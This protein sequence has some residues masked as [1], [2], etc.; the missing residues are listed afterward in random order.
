MPIGTA[1]GHP[2][3]RGCCRTCAG[4]A[5]QFLTRRQTSSRQ[6]GGQGGFPGRCFSLLAPV[7]WHDQKVAQVSSASD[8]EHIAANKFK[9]K[10]IG[11]NAD[12][13]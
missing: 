9:L 4:V 3:P 5:V 13:R 11:F 7:N 10:F 1:R 12:N 6:Q 2:L 8:D